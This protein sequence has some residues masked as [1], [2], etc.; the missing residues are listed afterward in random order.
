MQTDFLKLN[1]DK[2]NMMIAGP[3]SLTKT[4]N[5]CL[6]MDGSTLSPSP[7]TCNLSFEHHANLT[8]KT[9]FFHLKNSSSPLLLPLL[10]MFD[11]MSCCA[12]S[13]FLVL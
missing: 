12:F 13:V 5:F 10:L 7:H 6:T 2:S 1:Y 8:V 11:L 3:K 4:H 9:A